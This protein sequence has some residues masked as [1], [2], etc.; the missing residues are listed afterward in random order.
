MDSE[1][2]KLNDLEGDIKATGEDLVGDAL[3]VVK[4][5]KAKVG[6]PA[7][8]PKRPALAEKAEA[9]AA[10]MAKK[11]RIETQLVDEAKDVD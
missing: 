6:L 10:D 4:I 3:D 1:R 8:D 9:M 7:D 2:A 11:T 5:E